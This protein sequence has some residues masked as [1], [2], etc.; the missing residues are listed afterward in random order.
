MESEGDDPKRRK[1]QISQEPSM[2]DSVPTL[3]PE[4]I[5]EIFARLPVKSLLQFRCVSKYW[6][7]EISSPQFIKKHLRLA[8]NNKEDTYHMLMY[9]PDYELPLRSCT[10]RS[11]FYQNVTDT[12]DLDYPINDYKYQKYPRSNW[13]LGSAN[14]LICF[15]AGKNDLFIGNPSIRK[16]RKLPCPRPGLMKSVCFPRYSF[17]YDEFH[18]DYKVVALFASLTISNQDEVEI[19]SLKG[20]S[21]RSIDHRPSES[22]DGSGKFLN[23]NFIGLM[24]L[25]M[26]G[27]SILLIWL[28][29]NGERQ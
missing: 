26:A 13:I 1:I 12:F 9:I 10:L 25:V 19:Y 21:W 17:G 4:L 8:V 28:T 18:D 29:R 16:Y 20:D 11:M 7:A 2:E 22:L 14:G 6:F 23:G 3:L 15:A 5:S 24:M 27:T